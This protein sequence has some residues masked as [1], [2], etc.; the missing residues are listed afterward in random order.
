M[1]FC[2]KCGRPR[3]GDTRFCTGCGAEFPERAAAGAEAGQQSLAEA[4]PRADEKS[5]P[6]EQATGWDE[7]PTGWD[8]QPTRWDEQPTRWDTP[9]VT[10]AP[11]PPPSPPPPV[12]APPGQ[13]FEVP[14]PDPRR[15]RSRA[16]GRAAV[17][18][19]A[20]VILLAA[21]GGAYAL[22]SSGH[23]GSGPSNASNAADQRSASPAAA[24]SSANAASTS[25]PSTASAQQTGNA[26][27]TASPSQSAGTVAV[28]PAVASNPAVPGVEALLNSYFQ[29]INTRNYAE[30]N[31]LLDAAMQAN[32][33]ASSFDS[34]YA[35]TTDSAETLTAISSSGGEVAATVTFTSHQNPADS[36]DES[37]CNDWTVTLYLTPDGG[38]YVI[39]APPSGYKASYTDC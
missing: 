21:G 35:T 34:G 7:Q 14:P 37:S 23:S 28:A 18:A 31:S 19:A 32:E 15:S 12:A 11:P 24:K 10:I 27:A 20:V 16:G 3:A 1:S 2:T 38:G 4:P 22:I 30:Y 33:S 6:A 17:V 13:G 29:A 9:P 26:T 36:V 39:T 5:P 8:E 25:P